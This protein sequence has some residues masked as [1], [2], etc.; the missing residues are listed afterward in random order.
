MGDTIFIKGKKVFV[1]PMIMR[2][3]AIQRLKTPTT[4]KGWRSFAGVINFLCLLC[5]ELQKL[6]KPI[7]DLTKKGR[8][9]H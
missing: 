3:W 8:I 9:F 2:I 1:K 4:P 7:Y 5:S 6:L